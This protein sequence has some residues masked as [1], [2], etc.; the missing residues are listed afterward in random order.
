MDPSEA[1][2]PLLLFCL[3]LSDSEPEEAADPTTASNGTPPQAEPSR[4]ERTALSEEAFQTLK[5]TYRPKLENGDIHKTI[6]LPLL[7]SPEP[8]PKPSA[9]EILHAAEELYFFRRY[10]EAVTFIDGVFDDSGTGEARLDGETK[11]SLR[12]YRRRCLERL[13]SSSTS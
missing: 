3:D 1:T 6:P 12:Y 9:Q 7:P 13:E 4:A 11:S 8:L 5:Q 2:D 10:R